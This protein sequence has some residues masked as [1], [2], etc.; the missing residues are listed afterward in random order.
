VLLPRNDFEHQ[1]KFVGEIMRAGNEPQ[2]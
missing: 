2:H 1:K